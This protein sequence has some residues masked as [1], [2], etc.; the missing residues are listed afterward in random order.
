M[1]INTFDSHF[2]IIDDRFPLVPNQGYLPPI[3]T[4][5][6]YIQSVRAQI[7]SLTFSGGAIV[8]GSFQLYDQLYLVDAIER[9]GSRY[10]GV[11]QLST[12]VSDEEIISLNSKGFLTSIA[13]IGN[14]CILKFFIFRS[15]F[16]IKAFGR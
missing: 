4:T 10:V 2:H 11:T 13:S 1:S 3:F 7:P 15:I 6:D 9:L 8:S 14:F 16:A 5:D 12:D